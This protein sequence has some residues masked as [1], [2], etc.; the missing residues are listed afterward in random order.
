MLTL[1]D[2][3]TLKI[4][5]TVDFGL[6][7]DGGEEGEILLIR[8]GDEA[9]AN[10]INLGLNI[11]SKITIADSDSPNYFNVYLEGSQIQISRD[12]AYN[13]FLKTF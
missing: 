9:L 13:I 5:K 12:L 3:N 8:G 10:S 4:V 2:Y 7:L 1:G 6:Y 11:G